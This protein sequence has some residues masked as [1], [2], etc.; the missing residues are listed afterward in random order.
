MIDHDG[1]GLSLTGGGKK[2]ELTDFEVDPGK[3]VLTGK[4]TVDGKV[5]AESAPLFFLD[6]RTLKP[7]ETGDNGTA[8]LEGTT[9]KLKQE[10]ADLLNQTFG[11]DALTGGLRDRRRQDHGQ[12][13]LGLGG[14]P[15]RRCA[16]A[17]GRSV[18]SRASRSG[19]SSRSPAAKVNGSTQ[20]D[21]GQEA[22]REALVQLQ[23][24]EHRHVP[25]VEA[26]GERAR[27]RAAARCRARRPGRDASA[28]TIAPKP[29]A[30]GRSPTT[31]PSA[32]VPPLCQTALAT[33]A[34]APARRAPQRGAGARRRRRARSRRRTRRG[35]SA[36]SRSPRAA[37]RRTSPTVVHARPA[38]I[39]AAQHEPAV[40]SARSSA[41]PISGSTT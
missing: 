14:Q 33:T 32:P 12:H 37:R 3:S 1:S 4:V 2:V 21:R 13:R 22:L 7:L 19:T 31:C 27:A 15:L 36:A 30:A 34:T 40:R 18:R 17:P 20:R 5:A 39:S 38:A 26:E 11:A 6:G 35:R 29:S 10:A 41:S 23:R 28:Q 8:I 25:Q 9:V 16:R 24:V